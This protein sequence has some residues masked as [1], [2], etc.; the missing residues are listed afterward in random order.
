MV[1]LKKTLL[2]A[3]CTQYTIIQ[4]MHN[5]HNQQE[6]KLHFHFTIAHII[7]GTKKPAQQPDAS[8]IQSKVTE[9]ILNA[10]ELPLQQ[11]SRSGNAASTRSSRVHWRTDSGPYWENILQKWSCEVWFQFQWRNGWAFHSLAMERVIKLF[12]DRQTNTGVL[13]LLSLSLKITHRHSL[14]SSRSFILFYLRTRRDMN[15]YN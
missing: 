3:G 5:L 15:I 10:G 1:Q 8:K 4:W 7:R 14:G 6:I 9:T 13:F 12:I 11:V 2:A